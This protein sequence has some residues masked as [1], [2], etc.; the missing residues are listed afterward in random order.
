MKINS[1]NEWDKLREVIVG[2]AT[3][4]TATL[5]WHKEEKIEEKNYEEALKICREATPKRI[6]DETNED[7]SNLAKILNEWGAKVY[8]PNVHDLS[9]IYSSPFWSSNGNNVYNVRD[10]NLVIGNHVIESPSPH[11]SRYFETTAMYDIWYKYF[12]EGFTWISAPKP[13]LKKNPLQPYYRN[14]EERAL[15]DEDLKY[16]ELTK[17][18]L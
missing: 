6:L 10:L 15:T 11:I 1:H 5:E 9:K 4:T 17:G 8:R 13:V 2:T 14:E 18:R 16:K 3:G 7:L 12:E